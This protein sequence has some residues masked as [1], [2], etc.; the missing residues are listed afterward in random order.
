MKK[1]GK[2][3]AIKNLKRKRGKDNKKL[4][5]KKVKWGK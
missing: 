4:K 3:R 2:R 5:Q 1:K